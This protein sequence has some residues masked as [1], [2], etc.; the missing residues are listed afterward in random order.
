MCGEEG[1]VQAHGA[2][3]CRLAW[4]DGADWSKRGTI[5]G[6]ATIG[7]WSKSKTYYVPPLSTVNGYKGRLAA[8]PD[9]YEPYVLAKIKWRI[10]ITGKSL[11]T[12]VPRGVRIAFG[13]DAGVSKH[14]RNGAEFEP[15]GQTGLTPVEALNAA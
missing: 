8:N 11:E 13:T 5:L 7:A 12:L 14:G 15:M 2:H 10:S 1:A 4:G 6:E 3:G 9:A